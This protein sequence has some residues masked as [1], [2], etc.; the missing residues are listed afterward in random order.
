MFAMIWYWPGGF[1]AAL[2]W[3]R[4]R[5]REGLTDG[6]TLGVVLREAWMVARK[7]ASRHAS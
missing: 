3:W 1:V 4:W 6:L 7:E 5:R 2:R